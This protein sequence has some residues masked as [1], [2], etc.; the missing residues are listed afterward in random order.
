MNRSSKAAALAAAACMTFASASVASLIG[1]TVTC[2]GQVAPITFTS[3]PPIFSCSSGSAVI[4]P[5]AI[6]FALLERS[7]VAMTID[8]DGSSVTLVDHYYIGV[9]FLSFHVGGGGRD[10]V[11][12]L[13]SL[14]HLGGDIVG[15]SNFHA[16]NLFRFDGK[17]PAET[18]V[19]TTADS[20]S[21]IFDGTTW[22]GG[23]PPTVTFDLVVA[24]R[25]RGDRKSV[26]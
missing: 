6:E 7:Y 25:I 18:F 24:P 4:A 9:G 16:P 26:V 15:I 20:V 3:P 22:A 11:I 5:Q 12:T 21:L 19:S 1:D 10:N 17:T 13:G 14:D 2:S 23:F 8:I